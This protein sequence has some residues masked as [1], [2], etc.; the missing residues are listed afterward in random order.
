MVNY[1]VIINILTWSHLLGI[2]EVNYPR[3]LTRHFSNIGRKWNWVI[4]QP[5]TSVIRLRFSGDPIIRTE[6]LYSLVQNTVSHDFR[7][8]S[9]Y[10]IEMTF[11]SISTA[12]IKFSIQVKLFRFLFCLILVQYYYIRIAL[13]MHFNWSKAYVCTWRYVLS[14]KIMVAI[15]FSYQSL[16]KYVHTTKL[17]SCT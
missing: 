11:S 12:L 7:F 9:D 2:I 5:R 17:L 8:N 13:P 16:A 14:C 1:T 10:V 15:Y 3:V 6:K 4:S